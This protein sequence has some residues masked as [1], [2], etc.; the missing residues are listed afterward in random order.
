[1]WMFCSS[2]ASRAAATSTYMT[3]FFSH[4]SESTVAAAMLRFIDFSHVMC[5]TDVKPSQ[6]WQVK[7]RE[8]NEI[9]KLD[10]N[11]KVIV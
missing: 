6:G 10:Q 9:K 8:R 3:V 2:R 4:D 7:F 11:V 5:V 1:M